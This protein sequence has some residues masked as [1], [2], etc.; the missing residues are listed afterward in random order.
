[1]AAAFAPFPH[2]GHLRH[3]CG[4][5][6]KEEETA[7]LP[8]RLRYRGTVKLHGTNS[9]VAELT[10]GDE[11]LLAQSR[12]RFV[13]VGA[14]NCGFAAFVEERRAAFAALFARVRSELGLTDAA[15]CRLF[16]EFAG[17]GVQKAVGISEAPKFFAIFAVHA[18]DRFHDLEAFPGLWDEASRIF[19][20][21]QFG[22]WH[23]ELLRIDAMSSLAEV[24]AATEAVGRRCPGAAFLGLEGPGEGLVWQCLD[25]LEDSA[26]WFKSKAEAT[27][28]ALPDGAGGQSLEA[29]AK[30]FAAAVV[31]PAR[32][33]QAEE[34]ARLA[35]K[36][37]A[38]AIGAIVVWIAEDALREEGQEL[39]PE[40][41]KAHRLAL[42]AAAR[43][44]AV[45]RV[46]AA[47]AAGDDV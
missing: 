45:G 40:E 34:A 17:K 37:G 15:P 12:T 38:A 4:F 3:L 7:T 29:R 9:A 25:R 22:V 41:V 24:D 44:W 46:T 20:V 11:L 13:E 14:D 43:S 31:T 8:P 47:A 5:L 21:L 26:L 23:L 32:L 30:A 35:G 33:E 16:G 39:A 19:N 42:C 36:V 2:I 6:K 27:P 18:G 1:M 28:A 10:S